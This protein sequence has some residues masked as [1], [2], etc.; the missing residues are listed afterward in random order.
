MSPDNKPSEASP[1]LARA[2]IG[3]LCDVYPTD[4]PTLPINQVPA[5]GRRGKAIKRRSDD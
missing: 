4:Q 3:K 5:L 2:I 1:Y